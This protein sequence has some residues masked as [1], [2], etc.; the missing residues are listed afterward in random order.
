MEAHEINECVTNWQQNKDEY[1]VTNLYNGI[2]PYFRYL[3]GRSFSQN[4]DGESILNETFFRVINCFDPNTGG[5]FTTYL[6]TAFKNNCI[7]YKSRF[8]TSGRRDFICVDPVEG[9]LKNKAEEY[10]LSYGDRS[11]LMEAIKMLPE[12]Q[13]QILCLFIDGNSISDIHRE[14]QISKDTV[15]MRMQY[16]ISGLKELLV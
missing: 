16:G 10:K 6:Y 15:H 7:E 12:N 11:D 9:D 14:L 3:L 8:K 4:I 1:S 13:S 5:K 2:Q